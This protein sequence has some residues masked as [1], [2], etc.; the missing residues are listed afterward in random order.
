VSRSWRVGVLD[1]V[2][3][4][5]E[6]ERVPFHASGNVGDDHGGGGRR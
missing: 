5:E 6:E 4:V 1:G 2:Q 3:E